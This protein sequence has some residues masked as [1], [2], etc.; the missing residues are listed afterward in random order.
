MKKIFNWLKNYLYYYKFRIIIVLI[1]AAIAGFAVFQVATREK[2]DYSVYL[3]IS[4][5]AMSEFNHSIE[6]SFAQFGED[7]NGDGKVNVQVID[8]SYDFSDPKS[9]NALSKTTLL[10]GEL[11][12]GGHYIFL[13]DD[14]YYEKTLTEMFEQQE[15][16]T[17]H[18]GT[19]ALVSGDALEYIKAGL[20]AVNFDPESVPE[21]YISLRKAPNEGSKQMDVYTAEK[22]LFSNIVG[23]NPTAK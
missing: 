22:K 13:Y 6:A 16:L 23:N 17:E 4:K 7:V 9:D 1:V 11:S 19:A 14:R 10:G 5:T 8:L 12:S 2:Y 18:D 15:G 20:T 21:M 3:C